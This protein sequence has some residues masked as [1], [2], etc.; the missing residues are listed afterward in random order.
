MSRESIAFVLEGIEEEVGGLK[1]LPP[2]PSLSS[3]LS[4]ASPLPSTFPS[5]PEPS[6]NS[7]PFPS[8][9]PPSPT[10]SNF[11]H[12]MFHYGDPPRAATP[13]QEPN[14]HLLTLSMFSYLEQKY[15]AHSLRSA[16]EAIRPLSEPIILPSQIGKFTLDMQP[17]S[18]GE[19][20]ALAY[21]YIADDHVHREEDPA[22][23]PS[24]F[25][26]ADQ[27][28]VDEDQDLFYPHD[29][30]EDETFS[31]KTTS[32]PSPFRPASINMCSESLL[33]V[34]DV[35]M[36]PSL[37]PDLPLPDLPQ[38]VLSHA[39]QSEPSLH[40]LLAE[41]NM[42]SMY[43]CFDAE[44]ASALRPALPN[45]SPIGKTVLRRPTGGLNNIYPPSPVSV[46]EKADLGSPVRAPLTSRWSSS[47]SNTSDDEYT[48]IEEDQ[49]P[50]PPPRA[51]SP[52]ALRRA[53]RVPHRA[54]TPFPRPKKHSVGKEPAVKIT[55]RRNAPPKHTQ[56][57]ELGS[58]P[59]PKT[60]PTSWKSTTTKMK[61]PS[62]PPPK[63]VP[64]IV[65]SPPM[66]L[67]TGPDDVPSPTSLRPKV[68]GPGP[69]RV[70][71][72]RPGAGKEN[73]ARKI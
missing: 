2:L 5:P 10:S 35:S 13:D 26:S 40:E 60:R 47:S 14:V 56:S 7:V 69:G 73:L 43:S 65:I 68:P 50:V 62:A 1:P 51:L 44:I 41:C 15:L 23:A 38:P 37:P 6:E 66:R 48:E 34:P 67:G 36:P 25:Y 22:E 21:S 9:Y 71:P 49:V 28:L 46:S 64:G 54:P 39:D 24:L 72:K 61:P 4:S 32:S 58:S 33:Q 11:S 31:I 29:R 57:T 63:K 18:I 52:A 55:L 20:H 30:D 70:V 17:R 53:N 45:S 19:R 3:A 12:D 8:A 27:T 42:A 59:G 16:E